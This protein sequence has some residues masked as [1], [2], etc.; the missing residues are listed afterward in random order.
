MSDAPEVWRVHPLHVPGCGE[1]FVLTDAG[2]TFGREPSNDVILASARFPGVSGHHARLRLADGRP[3]LE[4]LGSRNGTL[5]GDTPIVSRELR[6]GEIFQLGA[7]GPRF[8]VVRGTRL[9]DTLEFARPELPARA[10]SLGPETIELVK[11]RLGIPAEGGVETLVRSRTRRLTRTFASVAALLVLGLGA[12]YS[13]LRVRHRE[14]QARTEQVVADLESRLASARAEVERQRLAWVA[15]SER[16]EAARA[17]WEAHR[18]ELRGERD[19]L[20]DS[21][22]RLEEEERGAQDE[23]ARLRA[24]L[25]VTDE[26]LRRLDP[27]NLELARLEDVSRVERA[28][29]FIEAE[30]SLREAET[31]RELYF[32]V[33]EDGARR[34][35]FAGA[36]RRFHRSGS[37]S[38]FCVSPDGWIVTNAHVVHKKHGDESGSTSFEELE[39]VHHLSIDVVFSGESQR[40]PAM[41]VSSVGEGDRDLALLKIEP[42]EGMPHVD[43]FDPGLERPALG[44]E[45]FLIGFPLGKR[46]L[47]AGDRMIASTFRGI[48]SRSV[49]SYLQVDAA[50]HPGASGGPL[51]DGSGRVLGV[52][53]GMQATPDAGGANQIGYI[54]PVTDVGEIW[55]PPAGWGE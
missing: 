36:G 33:D 18:D 41:L 1:P 3:L 22:G 35:N 29:V 2:L 12:G 44:T 19:A 24:Q 20:L 13:V 42:F 43:G 38:G 27:I 45:V 25:D 46:A 39:L 23:L 5:V 51:I 47:Q 49:E 6:R 48:V 16:L 17:A 7:N 32:D 9:E 26:N 8:S 4:D 55:P 50:V 34:A 37:G 28:V 14:A 30:L 21:I 40:H 15:Q 54:I 10:R 52:V 53:V 11:D 31:G